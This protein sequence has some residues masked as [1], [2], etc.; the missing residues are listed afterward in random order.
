MTYRY[1]RD[2]NCPSLPETLARY[3]RFVARLRIALAI[4][5]ILACAAMVAFHA[6]GDADAAQTSHWQVTLVRG[7]TFVR[8]VTG[9]TADAALQ[10]CHNAVPTTATTR[11]EYTCNPPRRIYVVTADAT[12]PTPPPDQTRAG[13]C[14]SGTTSTWTQTGKTTYG[15]APT[16]TPTVTWSPA[17][18]PAGGCVAITPIPP[19][20]A[21][22]NSMTFNWTHDGTNTTQYEVIYWRHGGIAQKKTITDVRQRSTSIGS[23]SS[24][25]WYGFVRAANCGSSTA[26]DCAYSADSRTLSKTVS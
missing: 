15:P 8:N 26:G 21:P 25:T 7:S 11:T 3:D 19:D 14:P 17:T 18:A 12:C 1:H 2:E 10:A 24:G 20:P 9:A 6:V 5:I 16:C 22:A 4:V 13:A 23:L